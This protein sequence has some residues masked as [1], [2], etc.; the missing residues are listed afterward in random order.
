M[1]QQQCTGLPFRDLPECGAIKAEEFADAALDIFNLAVYL[2]GG[3]FVKSRGEF[4]QQ[5]LEL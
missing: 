4:D 1:C 5:R 3:Q 2:V